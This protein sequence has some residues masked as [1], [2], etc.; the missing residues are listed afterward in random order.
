MTVVSHKT[1]NSN[2]RKLVFSK[3]IPCHRDKVHGLSRCDKGAGKVQRLEFSRSLRRFRR[4]APR[5]GV[6]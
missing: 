4:V 5:L 2:V 6:V 3:A 1:V